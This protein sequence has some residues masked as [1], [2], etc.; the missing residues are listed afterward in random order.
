MIELKRTKEHKWIFQKNISSSKLMIGF[1][2]ANNRLNNCASKT[3]LL[4]DL[5]ATGMYKGRSSK[6]SSNTMG[7]RL[8]EFKFYMFAYS[9][10]ESKNKLIPSPM[11]TSI[12]RDES[13]ENV[14][15][16]SLI[17][18]FSMQY[19]HPFSNT[20]SCFKINAGRLIIKLLTEP[21]LNNKI[22]IDEFCYFV[23]FIESINEKLYEELIDSIIEFRKMSFCQKDF[24]FKQV[25]NYDDVFSNVF[26]E[27]NY[28]FF[29][30]FRDFGVL[31][32]IKD[33]EYNEGHLHSFNHGDCGTKR[34]D[35][36]DSGKKESG[37]VILSSSLIPLAQKLLE[38]YSIFEKPISPSDKDILS[39]EDYILG[40]YQ[41]KPLK[42]LSTI[43]EEYKRSDEVSEIIDKMVHASKYGSRDG[44]EL[45]NA[46]KDVF[47]L[48]QQV[49]NVSIISGS[50]DTDLL[51]A[52]RDDNDNFYNINVDGKTS[53]TSTSALN[54]IRLSKHLRIHDSKYCIVVSSR[55]AH[56]VSCDILGFP[57][58]AITAQAL[59]NYCFSG[60][61]ASDNGFI[62][63]TFFEEL[64]TRYMGQNITKVIN[65]FVNSY[66]GL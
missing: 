54:P 50:G 65:E 15:K 55:F 44:K 19:P 27:F 16:M 33:S 30:M 3:R 22:Y 7:V 32:I 38:N 21:R 12:M 11:A 26:H 39:Q 57:I 42:Y 43:S 13:A 51:C 34:N 64:A 2:H 35:A 10:P 17:N 48:F 37:Y 59:A 56:G 14:A 24:L 29:R 52:L 41:T 47:E 46:L 4:D 49:E 60:Y 40:I 31:R 66:Y 20:P 45:E 58:V 25:E 8:S 5:K 18:L 63:F 53:G 61:N 62:D 9:L 23:P 1:L 6:G 36:Y 28:Y